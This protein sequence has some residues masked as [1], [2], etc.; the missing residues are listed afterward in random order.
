MKFSMFLRIKTCNKM[1]MISLEDS[2]ESGD[3]V[4]YDV[5]STKNL[6]SHT[7]RVDTTVQNQKIILI[8]ECYN[9]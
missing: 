7:M 2:G 8:T 5:I 1:H 6:V 9:G 4:Q 3:E